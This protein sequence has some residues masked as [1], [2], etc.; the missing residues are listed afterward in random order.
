MKVHQKFAKA[1]SD[2]ESAI[3]SLEKGYKSHRRDNKK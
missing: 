3:K 1:V 2:L